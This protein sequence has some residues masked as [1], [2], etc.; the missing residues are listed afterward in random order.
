MTKLS[1]LL[2][3]EVSLVRKGANQHAHVAIAKAYDGDSGG[4]V[5]EDY[6]DLEGNP[7][8]VNELEFGDIVLDS[9][10]NAL[11]YSEVDDEM[12]EDDDLE[13]VGKSV[14][15]VARLAAGDARTLARSVPM[16]AK[17]AYARA[18]A[19]GMGAAM[20]ARKAPK[21][22]KQAA[23]FATYSKPAVGLSNG[24]GA[25]RRAPGNVANAAR[26]GAGS[27][28]NAVA[29]FA[30]SPI[31]QRSIGAAALGGAGFGGGYAGSRVG[32]SFEDEV[33]VELSKALTDD[34]R[35][36]VISKALGYMEELEAQV[37]KAQEI[38]EEEREARLDAEFLDIAKSYTLPVD[39]EDL[40]DALRACAEYL[41]DDQIAVIRKCLEVASDVFES[42]VGAYGG[43]DNGDVMNR[44]DA[45]VERFAK[46]GDFTRES[47]VTKA[48]E[49][50]GDAYDQYLLDNP[51]QLGR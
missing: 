13:L 9:E 19:P 43:A 41:E 17:R 40:A 5:E 46:S 15:G 32:K 23:A 42:E 8:D 12:S 1:D 33:R 37:S 3:D 31:G 29:G 2:I 26:N 39:D 47:L 18:G 4:T 34:D 21:Q 36:A 25:V 6:F 14:G 48:F 28:Q 11:Q 22:A 45:Q 38:A 20:A 27:A 7:V 50:D 35:D 49:N 30:R 24:A 44:V 51:A 16:R 10:G